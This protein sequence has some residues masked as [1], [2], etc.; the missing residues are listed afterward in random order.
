M[1]NEK[2]SY[3]FFKTL[4]LVTN[5][6]TMEDISILAYQWKADT[7]YI[8][9]FEDYLEEFGIGGKIWPSFEEYKE[10]DYY[11]K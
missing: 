2:Q 4:W 1:E 10:S 9:D 7:D 5:Q 8:G 6:I 3:E 11:F